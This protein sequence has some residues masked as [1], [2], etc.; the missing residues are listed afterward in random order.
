[1]KAGDWI[2][3][4]SHSAF[5]ASVNTFTWGIPFWHLSHVGVIADYEGQLLL[6]ES[7]TLS[8]VPCVIQRKPVR[9]VQAVR[10]RDRL[11]K[12]QGKA[13]RYPLYRTLYDHESRRLTK[14]LVDRL[15][16]PYDE[17]AA[18]E[19]AGLLGLLTCVA[20]KIRVPDWAYFC[21]D[22]GMGAVSD[23]GLIATDD[24]AKWNP[25]K[26]VRYLRKREILLPRR[27]LK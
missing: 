7:T 20:T 14:F 8:D 6:F 23:V 12:Y 2:G 15:G 4:S 10:L 25:N 27:R 17:R 3:F 16:R 11:A 9:G 22:L 18:I 19:S 5:G 21:S 13:W 24:S 1:M 26:A